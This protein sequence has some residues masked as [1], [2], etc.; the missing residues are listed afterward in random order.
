MKKA[1]TRV[2]ELNARFNDWFY[3]VSDDVYRKVQLGR[4]DIVKD[5]EDG[6]GRGLRRRRLP[7]VGARRHSRQNPGLQ[8]APRPTQWLPRGFPPM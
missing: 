2:N 8:H 5:R 3:V 7:Q 1:Q 4:A 6:Q